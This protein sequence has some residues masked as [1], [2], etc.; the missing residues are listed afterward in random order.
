MCKH[1][2]YYKVIHEGLVGACLW[3]ERTE[4]PVSI[5]QVFKNHMYPEEGNGCPTFRARREEANEH[6]T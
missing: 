2:V 3:L 1:C 6:G 4:L 5:T